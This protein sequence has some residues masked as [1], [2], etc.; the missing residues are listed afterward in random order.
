MAPARAYMLRWLFRIVAECLSQMEDFK[1]KVSEDVKC[2]RGLNQKECL[3]QNSNLFEIPRRFFGMIWWTHLLGDQDSWCLDA[4]A[5][6]MAVETATTQIYLKFSWWR[7]ANFGRAQ[8]RYG[9][10]DHILSAHFLR[11]N[12][13]DSE[14]TDPRWLHPGVLTLM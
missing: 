6:S 10:A 12:F 13:A 11:E 1:R 3:V 4:R 5:T 2:S 8:S 14:E 7:E 9:W